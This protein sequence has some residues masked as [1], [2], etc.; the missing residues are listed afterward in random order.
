M[1]FVTI[2]QQRAPTVVPPQDLLASTNGITEDMK[3]PEML[4]L[5]SDCF[6]QKK[7]M[8]CVYVPKGKV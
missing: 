2:V 4:R 3:H 7:H 8:S 1:I 5:K 6:I